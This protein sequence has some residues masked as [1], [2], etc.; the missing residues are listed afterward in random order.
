MRFWVIA[1]S[2]VAALVTAD[3][4]KAEQRVAFVVGNGDYKHVPKLENPADDATAMASLLRSVGFDVIE[5]TDLTRDAMTERLLAFGKKAQGADIALFYYSGLGLAVDGTGYLLPVDSDIKSEMDLKLGG[6]INIDL[7]LDETMS[8]AKI[9]LVFLDTGRD[10]PFAHKTN[11]KA[12]RNVGARQGLAEMKSGDGTLIVY[13]TGP[14]GR[15][16][17][18]A[19]GAHSPFTKALLANI[20]APG[21]EIQQAMSQVRAQVSDET[22]GQQMPWGHSNLAGAVYLNPAPTQNK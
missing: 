4:A 16:L 22:N 14:G 3:T 17:D 13:A 19:K 20:A 2:L 18:G 11:S 7:A 8:E 15:I 6:A 1:L 12:S 10:D 5:G 9:K 21:V